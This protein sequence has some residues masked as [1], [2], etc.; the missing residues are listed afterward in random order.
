M[1]RLTIL[2]D[3]R[4]IFDREVAEFSWREDESEVSVRGRTEPKPKTNFA[5]LFSTTRRKDAASQVTLTEG[6]E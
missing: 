3:G 2:Y 5:D 4:E 6:G 1:K